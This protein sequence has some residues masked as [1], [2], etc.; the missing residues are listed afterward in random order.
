MGLQEQSPENDKIEEDVSE[1]HLVG[2]FEEPMALHYEGFM[3]SDPLEGFQAEASNKHEVTLEEIPFFPKKS[4]QIED[5]YNPF[6]EEDSDTSA[7]SHGELT[8][9]DFGSYGP[10]RGFFDNAFET[11]IVNS[12]VNRKGEESRRRAMY[13][14]KDEKKDPKK[15]KCETVQKNGM[16]CEVLRKH[17]LYTNLFLQYKFLHRLSILS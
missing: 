12:P 3:P 14:N 16:T 4:V 17:N 5:S 8:A 9:K 11:E 6:E 7:S 1:S 2:R 13:D 10:P 15:K